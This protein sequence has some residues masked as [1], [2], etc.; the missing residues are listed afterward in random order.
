M[1]NQFNNPYTSMYMPNGFSQNQAQSI[2]PVFQNTNAQQQYLANQLREQNQYSQYHAPKSSG[3]S[4]FNPSNLANALRNKSAAQPFDSTN[5]A[6]GQN[7]SAEGSG[8]AGN[9]GYYPNDYGG[10][11]SWLGGTS[12]IDN[13][14]LGSYDLSGLDLGGS[15]GGSGSGDFLSGIGESLGGIGDWFAGLFGSGGALAG[16]GETAAEAAPV[17]AAA[18]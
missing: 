13:S 4:G 6:T 16:A 18:L 14:A 11:D 2:N 3:G 7:W 15:L 17:V 5:P 9:G 1:D 12:G 8:L 10:I